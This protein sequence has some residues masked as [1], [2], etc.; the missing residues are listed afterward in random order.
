MIAILFGLL[1]L[2]LAGF[3]EG[4]WTKY[5]AQDVA[6]WQ[7]E[8]AEQA[9]TASFH[10]PPAADPVVPLPSNPVISSASFA[11]RAKQ[12]QLREMELEAA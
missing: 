8:A 11:P 9:T 10:Q 4:V 3:R 2:F 5:T 12:E 1:G 7:V 6:R